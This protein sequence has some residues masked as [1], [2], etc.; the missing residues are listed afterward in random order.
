MLLDNPLFPDYARRS[1]AEIGRQRGQ[2]PHD[3]AL[4]LLAERCE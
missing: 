3:A 4:D 2:D 1:L